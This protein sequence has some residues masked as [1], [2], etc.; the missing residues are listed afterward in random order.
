M[1]ENADT[2]CVLAEEMA[3]PGTAAYA[4]GERGA[5]EKPALQ[6]GEAARLLLTQM[7]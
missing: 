6:G 7:H 3:L 2:L 4:A 5:F 1:A